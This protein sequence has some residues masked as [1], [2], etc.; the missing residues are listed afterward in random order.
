[1]KTIV[2]AASKGG[3]GKSTLCFNV[4]VE[5]SRKSQVFM[6]DLDPQQSLKRMWDGRSDLM[7]PRLVT[8]V[9]DLA[10]SVRLLHEA[11]YGREYMFVDTPGSFLDHIARTVASADLIVAPVQ[12][13]AMDWPAQ[14]DLCDMLVA[15]GMRDR[16]LI[17]INRS[18]GKGDLIEKTKEYFKALCVPVAA[19]S[20]PP[21]QPKILQS[22]GTHVNV[23]EW[24]EVEH[25]YS[26][27]TCSDGGIGIVT[28]FELGKA[29]VRY[30][31]P[32]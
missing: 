25:C 5:A 20:R 26:V 29:D 32:T 12:P 16:L 30:S 13:S 21:P 3:T 24:V 15:K 6:A 19:M 31:N 10:Q 28:K 9:T 14:Q 18:E 2:F 11:G 27:G 4:A 17:V 23:G 1:M 7:N 8:K 22:S